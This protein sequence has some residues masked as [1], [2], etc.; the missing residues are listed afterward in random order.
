M[1]MQVNS[2]KKFHQLENRIR[3]VNGLNSR[4]ELLL[5]KELTSH[6]AYVVGKIK[7]ILQFKYPKKIKG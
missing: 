7:V 4:F 1:N 6:N 3:V 5:E 2:E